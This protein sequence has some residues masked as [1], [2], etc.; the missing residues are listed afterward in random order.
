M[1]GHYLGEFAITYKPV[2]HGRPGIA[3]TSAARFIPL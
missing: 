1:I 3:A 2:A